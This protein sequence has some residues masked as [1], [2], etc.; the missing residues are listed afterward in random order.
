MAKLRDVALMLDDEPFGGVLVA[1]TIVVDG[2]ELMG[3]PH[4]GADAHF[5][6]RSLSG[7]THE[8]FTRFA[9]A[10]SADPSVPVHEETVRTAVQFRELTNGE[11]TRYVATGEGLDKAG[12][13]A[14]QGVGSFAISRIEGSYS[15]VVGLPACEVVAALCRTG[16][17]AAYPL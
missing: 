4:D 7:R 15:N 10:S 12:A 13:Y 17:L 16:L 6:L 1:D 2:S 14:A 9:L 11:I 8:V 3:K 5:M